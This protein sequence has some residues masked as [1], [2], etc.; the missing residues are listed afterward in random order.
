MANAE[1]GGEASREEIVQRIQ[2]MESMVA[3]GRLFTARCGWI[4]VL[5]G[6]VG[7]AAIGWQ[8]LQPDS[9]WVG[10]WAWPICLLAGVVLTVI[11]KALQKREHT[12]GNG[13]RSRSVEAVWGMM[14][15]ALA[16]Y[17]SSAI[18]RHLAWQLSFT[19]GT[20]IV[21]GMAHAISA[22]ILRWR[23]QGVV[24]GIW[25]AGAV[26]VLFAHS[27]WDLNLVLFVEMG[28]GMVLFG[29][30]AMMMERRC[31]GEGVRRND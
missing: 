20:L 31:G 30:Y 29:L 23:V 14:G 6:L 26:A 22:T 4:F 1:S 28:V 13:T 10:E 3:E 11:G 16:I 9:H 12:C 27:R 24:A 15:I 19:A 2:L 5:W 7:L 8:Y 17:F 21:V 18:A 25:W